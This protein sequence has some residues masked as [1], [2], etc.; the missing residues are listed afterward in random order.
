M[1]SK[2]VEPRS[3]IPVLTSFMEGKEFPDQTQKLFELASLFTSANPEDPL[4]YLVLG[5]VYEQLRKFD[6][7]RY[8]YRKA[9][10]IDPAS[11]SAWQ[12]LVF[13]STQ[14]SNNDTLLHD[15]EDAISFFPS[16]PAFYVYGSIAAIQLKNFA[17][18][19]T[20]ALAGLDVTTPDQEDIILQ[21]NATLGDAYHY[22][23]NTA[24][25]DS[26]Y[27]ALIQKDSSNAYALNNYAYF[28]SLRKT[29]LETAERLSRKSLD[30]DP[31][32][33]SY[34]DTYGWILFTMGNFEQAKV[35]I[36]KSLI[37]APNNAEVIEHLGDVLFRLGDT[38]GALSRWKK[39]KELGV[40]TPLLNKK[41]NNATWYE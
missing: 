36:E 37:A 12:Q 33:A 38:S 16:E 13:C 5:D 35:Y 25:S 19:I 32:N 18:C 34:L 28:L 1:A 10:S 17:K 41:I 2:D 11:Y 8:E 30:L 40:D 9:L 15:C 7:A 26:I 27:E 21:L 29:K 39:A 24:A 23:N 3:K 20:L 4:P 6:S 22:A 14:I 31:G